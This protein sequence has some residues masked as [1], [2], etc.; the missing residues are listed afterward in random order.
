MSSAVQ[1][2]SPTRRVLLRTLAAATLGAG[3]GTA[4]PAPSPRWRLAVVPQLTPVEMYGNWQ[5]LVEALSRAGIPCELVIHPTIA[6]FEREFLAGHADLI[7]LNP[8]H[9]VMAR[10]AHGYIPLVRDQRALEGLLLVAHD[11]AARSLQDLKDSRISFPAPNA[12]GASLYIRAVLAQEKVPYSS[13]YAGNHRNA[14]RQVL[15]GDSAAAGLVRATYEL[16]PP[17]VRRALRVLYTT[18]AIAPHPIAAH[19][20]VPPALRQQLIDSLLSLARDPRHQ[21]LLQA[22]QMPGPVAASYQRD[23]APLGRLGLERFVVRQ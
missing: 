10:N 2:R 5:P 4:A 11:A 17:E 23:Y 19:P 13:H 3:A 7:Y 12:L 14:I 15:A 18:P 9:M 6:L 20:R 21:R 8:Y 1:L 16:E 22:V